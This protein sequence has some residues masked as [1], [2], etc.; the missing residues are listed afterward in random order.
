MHVMHLINKGV[1]DEAKEKEWKNSSRKQVMEAF[2][3]A[4]K[5]LKPNFKE[6]FTD[7]YD[8]VPQYLKE[9]R[10]EM[11]RHIRSK[12]TSNDHHTNN[13]IHYYLPTS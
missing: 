11:E 9:Q 6:M 5:T 10:D 2:A 8:D 4:E 1:W 7:V 12:N 3:K 13:L